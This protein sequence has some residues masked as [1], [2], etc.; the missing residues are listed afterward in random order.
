MTHRREALSRALAE[1]KAAGRRAED[2]A[3]DAHIAR[4]TLGRILNGHQRPHPLTAEAI[5]RALGRPV[6]AIFPALAGPVSTRRETP[7]NGWDGARDV[8]RSGW[9][10]R[11]G[12]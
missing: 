6:E 4:E 5:A 10:P 9:R 2:V 11:G 3:A 7:G 12:A 8:D 1:A